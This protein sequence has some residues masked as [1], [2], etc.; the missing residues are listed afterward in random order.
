MLHKT[1]YCDNKTYLVLQ[2]EDEAVEKDD[3]LDQGC[4]EAA[5]LVEGV[6]LVGKLP[7]ER[8]VYVMQLFVR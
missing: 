3:A 6:Q 7:R 8:R 1:E 4:E 5:E 2:Q